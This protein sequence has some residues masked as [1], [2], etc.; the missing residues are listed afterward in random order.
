MLP[1]W[2]EKNIEGFFCFGCLKN[3]TIPSKTK[4]TKRE[5]FKRRIT[6]EKHKYN[7]SN[8]RIVFLQK[9]TVS[10]KTK[11][12][13]INQKKAGEKAFLKK[14]IP[15]PPAVS[16]PSKGVKV[17]KPPPKKSSKEDEIRPARKAA[18][19]I[20]R[21]RDF[22]KIGKKPE[23][24]IDTS[25]PRNV[26]KVDDTKPKKKERKKFVPKTEKAKKL[27]DDILARKAAKA[28]E[29]KN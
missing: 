5:N 19:P 17:G 24:R 20:P 18:P 25:G 28:A 2:F 6:F 21:A 1:L 7:T 4:K 10:K 26:G 8:R 11:P 12:Q 22:V 13:C 16:K 27:R 9:Y 23:G 29:S 3:Q 14:A 15:A